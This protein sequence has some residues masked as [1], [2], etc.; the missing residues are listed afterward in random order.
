[1]KI[2]ETEIR[3]ILQ[4]AISAPSGENCQPWL[5]K[6]E[7]E[8]LDIFNNPESDQS[9]YS[10]GQRAS[11]VAN[12]A[13]IENISLLAKAKGY[14]SNVVVFPDPADLNH[15]ARIS[16]SDAVNDSSDNLATYVTE[17][18]TNRK[19]YLKEKMSDS[20]LNSLREFSTPEI[21][22][23]VN[24]NLA[25]IQELAKVGSTN[26]NIMLDNKELHNFFF[27]HVSWTKEEDDLKKVGFFI[28][29]LELPAPAKLGF[30]LFSK[31]ERLAKIKKFINVPDL[32]AKANAQIYSSSAA[33]G[34]IT[35]SSIDSRNYIDAGRVFERLWIFLTKEGMS[36]QP[37]TGVLFMWLKVKAGE[38]KEFNSSQIEKINEGYETIRKIFEIPKDQTIALMFRIGKSKPASARSSKFKLEQVLK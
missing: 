15:V 36:L 35:I 28:E 11:F 2:P 22:V 6:L 1:M 32:V 3:T 17:R 13:L 26:E 30:K 10:W 14:Q 7:Q 12:G 20:L 16:F 31:W 23:F 24:E 37:L 18:H 9:V 5:F 4:D 21:K 38:T 8:F 19:P 27:S 33:I 29:T 34:I 25:N